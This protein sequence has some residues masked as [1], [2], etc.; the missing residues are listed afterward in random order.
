MSCDQHSA[1]MK[2]WAHLVGRVSCNSQSTVTKAYMWQCFTG[3]V[4]L[5]LAFCRIFMVK[6]LFCPAAGVR[7]CLHQS[8][9]GIIQSLML[10]RPWL[11]RMFFSGALEPW[12]QLSSCLL[13]DFLIALMSGEVSPPHQLEWWDNDSLGVTHSPSYSPVSALQQFDHVS[14]YPF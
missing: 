8:R 1:A 2:P 14:N 11:T 7:V 4:F 10:A 9:A 6:Y 13:R 3:Y 12:R 5:H